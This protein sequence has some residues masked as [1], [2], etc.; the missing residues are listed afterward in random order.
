MT[1]NEYNRQEKAD[2]KFTI[3]SNAIVSKEHLCQYS[4]QQV[5]KTF[6]FCRHT[7]GMG[8]REGSFPSLNQLGAMKMS[9]LGAIAGKGYQNEPQFC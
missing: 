3:L 5:A 4:K 9:T 8:E 6:I 1:G 2:T 7:H